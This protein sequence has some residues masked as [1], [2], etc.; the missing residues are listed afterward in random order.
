[1][2]NPVAVGFHYREY[3]LEFVL[4]VRPQQALKFSVNL[5]N[6]QWIYAQKNDTS[7]GKRAEKDERGH[8]VPILAGVER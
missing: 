2:T 1:M 5:V 8:R 7:F 4:S 3:T 6:S